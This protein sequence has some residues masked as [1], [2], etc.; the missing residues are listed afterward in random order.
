MILTMNKPFGF[1]SWSLRLSLFAALILA[2]VVIGYRLTIIDFQPAVLGLVG[3]ALAGLLA[4]FLG[5]IGTFNAIKGKEAEIASTMAGSTL[6]FLIVMPVLLTALASIGVPPIH[7]IT[8]DLEYPPEFV[9]IKML[10]TTAHNSLDRLEPQNLASL[11]EEGYPDLAPALI[12]QSMDQVF[13]AAVSLV[14]KRGWE[15]VAVSAEEGRIEAID[16]TRLMGFKDDVVIRVQAA[17]NQTQVD[18]RSVSRVG[19]SDLGA[20][21][22]RIRHF[23]ADLQKR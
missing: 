9:A 17:D 13:E 12:N 14:K 3:G 6:G 21:A 5:L 18:M 4:V 7:D 22:N 10:R 2:L 8:T 23:L 16:T 11:Q 1:T 19:K 15:I 20:N